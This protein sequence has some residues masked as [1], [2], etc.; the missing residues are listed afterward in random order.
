MP[1]DVQGA[2]QA[3]ASDDQ[4]LQYLT[5]NRNFDVQGALKA[6]ASK[7]QVIQYLANTPAP[8]QSTVSQPQSAQPQQTQDQ[9][10]F[11]KR[12]GKGLVQDLITPAVRTGQLLRAGF[13]GDQTAGTQ[14]EDVNIPVLGKYTIPPLKSVP[15]AIGESAKVASFA[16]GPVTGSAAYAGADALSKNLSAKETLKQTAIGAGIGLA[17]KGAGALAPKASDALDASAEKGY[18]QALAPTKAENKFLTSKITPQMAENRITAFSRTGLQKQAQAGMEEIGPKIED[19]YN[20]LP[21]DA[22]IHTD[23]LI[24]TLEDAKS[25]YVTSNV[26]PETKETVQ[27]IWNPTAWK[28]LDSLQQEIMRN[29]SSMSVESLRQAKQILDKTVAEAKGYMGKTLSEGSQVDAS[30]QLANAM[31][32]ELA[33]AHPDIA[34]LNKQYNFWSN[35][36]KVVTDTIAR[37]T[38]Q[39]T[40]L[41]QQIATAAGGAAGLTHGPAGAIEAGYVFKKIAQI[42]DSTAWKT[43][44]A[45]NKARLADL[46]SKSDFQTAT[47]LL[48]RLTTTSVFKS[49]AGN[50]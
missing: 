13:R 4:I 48:S 41:S 20:K 33:K 7:Q 14:P 37:K 50:K 35:L 8:G 46:L 44:S 5:T 36:N 40:P 49:K 31:R 28:N 26:N 19:A 17:F 10:G 2:K 3:G 12:V 45:A 27:S 43:I 6:G 1:F 23:P 16:M 30:K 34:A 24:K 42:A 15:Q 22:R 29:G 21:A 9:P 18:S 32:T 25:T 39:A 11:F 38:G 47:Q